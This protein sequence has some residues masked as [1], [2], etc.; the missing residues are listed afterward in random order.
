MQSNKITLSSEQGDAMEY[1]LGWPKKIQTLGGYAGTGKTTVI[2]YLKDMLPNF[3]VVAFTG[4]AAHVLRKKG[5]GAS[6]IHSC[7]YVPQGKNGRVVFKLKDKI[8]FDGFIVDE[9]SMVSGQLFD[10]L[11]SFGLPTIF[12]G[13]H[14]QLEPVGD[15]FNLMGDPDVTLET[16]H[17]NAGEISHFAEFIR[18]GGAPSDW[19]RPEE[20]TGEQVGLISP[21]E[22]LIQDIVMCDQFICAFNKTRT[23]INMDARELLKHPASRPIVGDRVMCLRNDHNVG[24]FNG[25]QGTIGSLSGNVM[26]F[27]S[28]GNIYQVKFMPEQFNS[29][30]RPEFN[31]KDRRIPFDYCYAITCHKAQGDE[32]DRVAVLEQK[33]KMWDHRRWAYTAASRARKELIW[34]C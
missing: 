3:A 20:C 23:S 1:L 14:G 18:K 4:K 19:S 31:I 25:M 17:R 12:V 5:V 15:K 11:M 33:C 7:I 8:D 27:E 26:G 24:V 21:D 28:D 32:W 30:H 16:V 9:A 2:R 10:D 29:L 6:T 34:V 22:M 13:D